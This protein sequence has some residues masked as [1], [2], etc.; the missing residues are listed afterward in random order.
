LIEASLLQTFL[1]FLFTGL[2]TN[3]AHRQLSGKPQPQ[4]T[5]LV[6]ASHD[7]AVTVIDREA[8]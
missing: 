3:A 1:A 2:L 5:A 6:P 4:S 7:G 8:A